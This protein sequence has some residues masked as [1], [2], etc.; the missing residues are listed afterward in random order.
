MR[1]IIA[2]MAA[3]FL[4][5]PAAAPAHHSNAKQHQEMAQAVK[6]KKAPK[7]KAKKGQEQYMRAVPSR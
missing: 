4:L 6:K 5:S 7:A 3:A 1:F 2:V